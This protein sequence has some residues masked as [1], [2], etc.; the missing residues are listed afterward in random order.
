MFLNIT[1]RVSGFSDYMNK[2]FFGSYDR[3]SQGDSLQRVA[4]SYVFFGLIWSEL[5]IAFDVPA[6]IFDTLP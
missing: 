4:A 6:S 2:R 3:H 1:Q 5:F